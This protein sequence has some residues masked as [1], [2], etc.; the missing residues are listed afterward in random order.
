MNANV[1]VSFRKGNRRNVL[2]ASMEKKRKRT[3]KKV[4]QKRRKN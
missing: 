3:K 2:Q 1:P 4:A